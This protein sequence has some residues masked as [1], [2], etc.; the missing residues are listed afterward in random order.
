MAEPEYHSR[1]DVRQWLRVL[2]QERCLGIE[3]ALTKPKLLQ[4][5]HEHRT[6][7]EL[8]HEDPPDPLTERELRR[9]ISDLV[10]IEGLDVVACTKGFFI[11]T[12]G[13][14]LL[15]GTRFLHRRAL[16]ELRRERQLLRNGQKRLGG[17]M[18]LALRIR[19]MQIA[20][21]LAMEDHGF[22]DDDEEAA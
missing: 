10:T 4:R 16:R 1:D 17:Q 21:A 9:A 20:A 14:E 15:M 3:N 22:E 7:I 13:E 6:A 2:L 12:S 8:R 11:P 18:P 19:Q 5:W